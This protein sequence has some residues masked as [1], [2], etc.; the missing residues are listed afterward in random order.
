MR[1]STSSWAQA[2]HEW[3][4]VRK[5]LARMGR[6]AWVISLI[7]VGLVVLVT[8]TQ[9]ASELHKYSR[10]RG[11]DTFPPLMLAEWA[12]LPGSV[13]VNEIQPLYSCNIRLTACTGGLLVHA[14]LL[15]G[16]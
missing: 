16:A 8:I 4:M 5:G 13:I 2:Q 1:L 7:Y 14:G 10:G 6:R 11:T 9:T 15:I 3:L 12:T